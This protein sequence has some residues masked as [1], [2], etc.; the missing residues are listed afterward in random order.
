MTEVQP[1]SAHE[2]TVHSEGLKPFQ[3]G[4]VVGA[5][6]LLALT[7]FFIIHVDMWSPNSIGAVMFWVGLWGAHIAG[8]VD[9]KWGW[10]RVRRDGGDLWLQL[11]S[12]L[13]IRAPIRIELSRIAFAKPLYDWRSTTIPSYNGG[14]GVRIYFESRAFERSTAPLDF[15]A[16]LNL[17]DESILKL[18]AIFPGPRADLSEMET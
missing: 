17:S 18:L 4:C 13:K 6:L 14:R 11:G 1:A 12:P 15:G 2:V 7:P 16:S 8:G 5:A 3:W 9:V 10:V